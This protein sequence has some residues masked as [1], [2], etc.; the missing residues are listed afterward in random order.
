[1]NAP[2]PGSVDIAKA[3]A[4]GTPID[5]AVTAGVQQALRMHKKMGNPIAVWRDG[6]V[7][8]IPPEEIPCGEDDDG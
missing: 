7:V 4:E 5:T 3:F 6:K 1:M 8:I 2:R